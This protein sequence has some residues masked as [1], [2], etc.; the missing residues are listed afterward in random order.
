MIRNAICVAWVSLILTACATTSE[1][2]VVVREIKVPVPV[3]CKVNLPPRDRF[4]DQEVDLS[5]GIFALVQ[6]ILAGN[7]EREERLIK[8]EA[9]IEACG[10]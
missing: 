4:A 2:R 5:A 7:S 9:A 1:P 6:S 3:S 10:R 8:A